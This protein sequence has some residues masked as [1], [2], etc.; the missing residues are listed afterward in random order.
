MREKKIRTA[1][2][3]VLNDQMSLVERTRLGSVFLL[4]TLQAERVKKCSADYIRRILE[5]ET[6]RLNFYIPEVERD[7][8]FR[9]DVPKS[10]NFKIIKR[11]SKK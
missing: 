11:G 7:W 5:P 8:S 2:E 1:F 3:A 4:A 9:D 6:N 10:Q